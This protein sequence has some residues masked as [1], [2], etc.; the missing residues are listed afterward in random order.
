MKKRRS[1]GVQ[2]LDREVSYSEKEQGNRI[3]AETREKKELRQEQERI[4][5]LKVQKKH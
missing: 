3:K 1:S 4:Q 2:Y 5:Q